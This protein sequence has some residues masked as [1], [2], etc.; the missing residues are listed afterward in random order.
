M[1]QGLIL[2]AV[3][4]FLESHAQMQDNVMILCS[5]HRNELAARGFTN[6]FEQDGKYCVVITDTSMEVLNDVSEW[7]SSSLVSLFRP[8]ENEDVE[9][10]ISRREEEKEKGFVDEFVNWTAAEN[11][12][13]E[14][15]K[16]Q[17]PSENETVEEWMSRREK[18]KEK[19]LL[20]EF[21]NWTT[22]ENNSVDMDRYQGPV[23]GETI[24][25]TE[26]KNFL[27]SMF[28]FWNV[29]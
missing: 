19:G 23:Q 10:W 20:D 28:D 24:V 17:E 11:D 13:R 6:I 5:H 16:P 21:I 25:K 15:D 9:E 3:F 22:G 18:E 29:D 4:L 7:L 2:L 14:V 8:S 1:K 27:D 26:N 12:G